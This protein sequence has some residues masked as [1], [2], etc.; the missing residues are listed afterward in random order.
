MNEEEAQQMQE[1]LKYFHDHHDE[2]FE[3]AKERCSRRKLVLR[4]GTLVVVIAVCSTAMYFT[5]YEGVLKGMEFVGAAVTDRL[6][7]GVWEV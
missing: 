6:L 1:L 3:S 4:C 5:H 7:F 2:L